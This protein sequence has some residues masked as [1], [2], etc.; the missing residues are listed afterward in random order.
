[1]YR[2]NRKR[3]LIPLTNY[4]LLYVNMKIIHVTILFE[5]LTFLQ[6]F[7]YLNIMYVNKSATINCFLLINYIKN[8]LTFFILVHKSYRNL[9]SEERRTGR[10]YIPCGKGVQPIYLSSK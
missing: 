4:Q 8:L 5:M 7:Q 9:S 3:N 1:M 2:K 6:L 10:D